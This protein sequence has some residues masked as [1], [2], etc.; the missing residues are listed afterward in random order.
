MIR[1]SR[2]EQPLYN[3]LTSSVGCRMAKLCTGGKYEQKMSIYQ[4][5]YN[6]K[7]TV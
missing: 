2:W 6:G 1:P 4:I 7:N 3:R 5:C